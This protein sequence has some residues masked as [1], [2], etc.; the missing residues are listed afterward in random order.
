MKTKSSERALIQ[1]RG[2]V[3]SETDAQRVNGEE[4]TGWVPDTGRGFQRCICRPRDARLTA[5]PQK[6]GR[7]TEQAPL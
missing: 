5:S 3:D 6:P 4:G 1:K 2:N 7:G